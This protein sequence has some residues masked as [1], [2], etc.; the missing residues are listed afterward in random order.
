MAKRWPAPTSS[1]PRSMPD[2]AAAAIHPSAVVD[3][4]AVI[5]EGA[6]IG[7]F[8]I[9]GP[10]VEIGAGTRIGPHC[11]LHGPT[12]I[13][14]DNHVHGHAAIGGEPQDKK[15]A[16]ERVGLEIGDRN[17]I[18]EVTTINRGTGGGGGVTRNGSDNKLLAYTHVAH[19]GRSHARTTTKH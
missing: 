5:G 7:A 1:V 6:S 11:S 15:F 2:M 13:G 16:G 4:S 10:E 9:V 3:P 8:T 12:R 17:V 19:T 14:R 18:R